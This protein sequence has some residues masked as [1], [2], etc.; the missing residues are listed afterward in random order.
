MFNFISIPG[1][2]EK[3]LEFSKKCPRDDVME[4]LFYRHVDMPIDYRMLIYALYD[5]FGERYPPEVIATRLGISES[6][7]RKFARY[8][9]QRQCEMFFVNSILNASHGR[10]GD[11]EKIESLARDGWFGSINPNAILSIIDKYYLEATPSERYF[12]VVERQ[13]DFQRQREDTPSFTR[14]VVEVTKKKN[15]RG[16]PIKSEL[17]IKDVEIRLARG[18]TIEDIAEAYSVATSTMWNYLKKSGL[19]V[20]TFR[21][22]RGMKSGKGRKARENWSEITPAVKELLVKCKTYK[23]IGKLLGYD[24][25]RVAQVAALEGYPRKSEVRGDPIKYANM[26]LSRIDNR[27]G[28]FEACLDLGM[29]VNEARF[30]IKIAYPDH[31]IVNPTR[32]E[33][34]KHIEDSGVDGASRYYGVSTSKI[35]EWAIK[36]DVEVRRGS[37]IGARKSDMIMLNRDKHLAK[38]SAHKK[39]KKIK[40]EDEYWVAT[41][42][43]EGRLIY[44]RI[45]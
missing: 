2:K 28:M 9:L 42:D 6:D 14:D 10:V 3:F 21:S 20:M 34:G 24:L 23:E 40:K 41:R 35:N 39:P 30:A 36:M 25:T 43:N 32:A 37:D 29:C 7:F 15:R 27:H 45:R 5:P 31:P 22:E 38:L 11:I 8:E 19:N 12:W 26:L 33:L 17:D 13:R 44:T 18:E 1:C 4:W 16:R